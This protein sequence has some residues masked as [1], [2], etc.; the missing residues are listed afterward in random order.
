MAISGTVASQLNVPISIVVKDPSG[1]IVL[2]GQVTPGSDGTYS[3]TV[4]A[5]GDLW[6]AVGSYEVDVTYGSK[7]NTAKAMFQFAGSTLTTPITIEGQ[8]YNATYRIT[9]GK[10]LGIVPDTSAKS[11]TVRIQSS[12]NGTLS[13]DLPRSIIDAK[14]GGQD[15]NYA[16]EEDGKVS[17]FNETRSNPT[18]RTLAIQ[19]GPS[20]SQI[21]ITGT[22][23]IPEFS[24]LAA[25][26]LTIAMLGAIFCFRPSF[27][28][29]G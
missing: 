10:V 23:I 11:L 19:F 17:P 6:T 2:I 7:D 4:T 16:V 8:E 26:V 29:V 5:G 21:T 13:I 18:S 12:G 24:A 20:T 9:N 28:P 14:S 1:N 3:T 25:V 27:N 22:Q 15:A